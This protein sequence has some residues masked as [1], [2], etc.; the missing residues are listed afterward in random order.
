MR[1]FPGIWNDKAGPS[2]ALRWQAIGFSRPG[3][4]P[5]ANNRVAEAS[6]SCTEYF[7]RPAGLGC[8]DPIRAYRSLSRGLCVRAQQSINGDM[9]DFAE[10]WA[11][12]IFGKDR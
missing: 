11:D 3:T 8:D 2:S 9:T 12:G 7:D 1:P 5:Y 10:R 6:E 4:Q